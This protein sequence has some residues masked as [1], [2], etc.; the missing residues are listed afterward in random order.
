[1]TV[2]AKQLARAARIWRKR[3]AVDRRIAFRA[4]PIARAT[5]RITSLV[6]RA[7]RPRLILIIHLDTL[8][9]FA[10]LLIIASPGETC[11]SRLDAQ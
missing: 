1:M 8:C 6:P 7:L 10:L 11:V 9:Y 2:T 3:Q 4:F 5:I